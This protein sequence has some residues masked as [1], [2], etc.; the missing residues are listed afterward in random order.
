MRWW[1]KMSGSIVVA[2]GMETYDPTELDEYGYTRYENV[3]SSIEFERLI[4]AGG[5]TGGEL[6]RPT[7]RSF[8]IPSVS[9]SVWVH[10][11]QKRASH[12]APISAA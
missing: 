4:S 12:T 9:F 11:R 5:P 10:A 3:L 1:S 7:D 8:P 2:T 6:V